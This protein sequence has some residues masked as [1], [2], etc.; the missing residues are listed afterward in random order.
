M[1]KVARRIAGLPGRL[2]IVSVL[3]IGPLG[4]A[5]GA[6]PSVDPKLLAAAE[7]QATAWLDFLLTVQRQGA[8]PTTVVFDAD[9]GAPQPFDRI[10]NDDSAAA[11]GKPFLWGYRIW[12]DDRYLRGATSLADFFIRAQFPEGGWAYQFTLQPDGSVK[13]V[14]RIANFE[15]WVQSNGLRHLAAVCVLTGDTRYRNAASKAGEVIL[16]AQNPA[17]WWPW[18]A[19]VGTEDKRTDY[20]KGP[21]LNDWS[22]NACMGDCLV[23]HHITGDRRYA[24]ALLEAG[25]WIMSAQLPDPTPGWAAQYDVQG[26][27]AWA[28]F[29]EPP[30]ADTNFGTYGAGSALLMLYDITGQD[31]YLA[32]LRKHLAW[33]ESIP[34]ARKGWMW[35][36]HRSWSAAENKGRPSDYTKSLTAKFGAT[37]PSAQAL[38]GIAVEAGEPIVAYHYQMVPVDHPE[39][40]CYL[41][42]LNGHYGSRSPRAESWLSTELETRKSGPI[43]PGWTGPVSAEQWERLRPTAEACGD[44]CRLASMGDVVKQFAEWRAGNAVR[45]FVEIVDGGRRVNI[46]RGC[47]NANKLLRHIAYA[48][49][50]LGKASP[51]IVPVYR[52]LPYFGDLALVDPPR[53]WYDIEPPDDIW[54]PEGERIVGPLADGMPGAGLDYSRAWAPPPQRSKDD[55][56]ALAA[57]TVRGT[58]EGK[59][60]AWLQIRADGGPPAR[61]IPE[62]FGGMPAAGGGPERVVVQTIG[63]L[64]VGDRVTVKWYV[65]DH[66]R[67]YDLMAE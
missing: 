27:A 50:A 60:R 55:R 39:L 23:L 37:L 28:R 32:P 3:L 19:P 10:V 13:P 47:A 62:W 44:A 67:I 26:R 53:D 48:H 7:E 36:A 24:V 59:G 21:T 1:R 49:V 65:T 6:A 42:P 33:L 20:M 14:W 51:D 45:G 61:Y 15:E 40:Q 34:A 4:R 56:I 38:A 2:A 8:L 25:N 29:M 57:G 12:K 22:L 9:T 31:R 43:I 46:A 17:G 30:G 54:P 63:G 35:Y 52:P 64:N 58:I 66:V 5:Q 11:L 16:K 41:K 18:G